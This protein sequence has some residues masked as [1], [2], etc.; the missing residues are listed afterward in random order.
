VDA[1]IQRQQQ[2]KSERDS[3]HRVVPLSFHMPGDMRSGRAPQS[4][5]ARAKLS[6]EKVQG[7]SGEGSIA[8]AEPPPWVGSAG[9][10]SLLVF[11]GSAMPPHDGRLAR[12]GLFVRDAKSSAQKVFL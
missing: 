1:G 8:R 4:G 10:L 9:R 12:G 5:Q 7:G 3:F 6:L 2:R 11:R